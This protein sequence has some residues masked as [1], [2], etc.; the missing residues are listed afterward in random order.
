M[1]EPISTIPNP[2]TGQDMNVIINSAS[3]SEPLFKVQ[4]WCTMKFDPSKATLT[5]EEVVT[6][7]HM[8][9]AFDKM[10]GTLKQKMPTALRGNL[11]PPT[12]EQLRAR[13]VGVLRARGVSVDA[14]GS[15]SRPAAA[16]RGAGDVETPRRAFLSGAASPAAAGPDSGVFAPFR[17]L[18]ADGGRERCIGRCVQSGGT[19]RARGQ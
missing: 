10:V 17:C 8:S 15:G 12:E 11:R 13:A 2:H 7:E 1:K 6:R 5:P 9:N 4:V 18:P 3:S 14:S 19:H 16:A